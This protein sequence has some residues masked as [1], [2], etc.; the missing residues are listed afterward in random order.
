MLGR[1]E[2]HHVP[3][4]RRDRLDRQSDI[5]H[6]CLQLADHV[7]HR[8][9]SVALDDIDRVDPVALGLAHALALAIENRRVNKDVGEGKIADIVEPH[10]RHAGN[11]EG[12]D[13]S[14]GNEAGAGIVIRKTVFVS[15]DGTQGRLSILDSGRGGV[16]PAKRAV[17]PDAAREPCIENIGGTF[18]T[19]LP[20]LSLELGAAFISQRTD[21]ELQGLLIEL[22]GDGVRVGASRQQLARSASRSDPH[23][24]IVP[25]KQGAKL[26]NPG[27]E[28]RGLNF[29]APDGNLVAPP[30]LAADAPVPLLCQPVHVGAA[31]AYRVRM[32]YQLASAGGF[33]ITLDG[34]DRRLC[35]PWGAEFSIGSP[36]ADH[37]I[38][39]VSHQNEPLPREER[40]GWC[41]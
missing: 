41:L 31:I 37:P 26:V 34:I 28:V 17:R 23:A 8:I 1:R 32:E 7:A 4:E 38:G 20:E 35:K 36:A 18:E 27:G 10:E 12:D 33:P 6:P 11:P 9:G 21:H 3:R 25:A 39:G 16:R 24:D 13:V 15:I 29:S 40:L 14:A 5:L 19:E 2:I 30:K 22:T